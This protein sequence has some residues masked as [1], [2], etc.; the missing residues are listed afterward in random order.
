MFFKN[1]KQLKAHDKSI[2][3]KKKICHMIVKN[4]LCN[5]LG[6]FLVKFESMWRQN[7]RTNTTAGFIVVGL[8]EAASVG[9][10]L[11]RLFLNFSQYPQET[12]VLEPLF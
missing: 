5:I 1:F 7:R 9:F 2:Q 8:S 10:L 12:P 11:E 3:A 6:K 4:Y